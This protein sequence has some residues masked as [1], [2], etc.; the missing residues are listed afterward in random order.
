MDAAFVREIIGNDLAVPEGQ[1]AAGLIAPLF[2]GL[3]SPDSDLRENSLT[4]LCEWIEQGR[5]EPSVLKQIGAQ[6][7]DNLMRGIG[8]AGTD[9]VFLRAFS[10]L[11]LAMVIAVDEARRGAEIDGAPFLT[12]NQVLDWLDRGLTY[13]RA[14]RD[15]R[16][17]V[18][19]KGWAHAAAH[20]A[21]LLRVLARH[22]R[23]DQDRLERI[24]QGI[25]EAVS[26]AT[27]CA[28]LH[29]E[30]E[31]LAAAVVA[32]LWRDE[33]DM[34][35]LV[36]WLERLAGREDEPSSVSVPEENCRNNARM[37]VRSFL[38]SLYFQLLIGGNTRGTSV[39][40]ETPRLSEPLREAIVGALREMDGSRFYR[41]A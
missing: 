4:V 39:G 19:G 36:S 32:V 35:F 37:N 10:V 7:A 3:G 17:Y 9:S 23:V 14:E 6:A 13:L 12:G 16:G 33:L 24:V 29:Q 20:A 38:R 18:P 8:E 5:Y 34:A 30:D 25:G 41:E 27:D 15:R 1:S 40:A 21:D 31:R 2:F 26:A 22:P 11:V 28:F